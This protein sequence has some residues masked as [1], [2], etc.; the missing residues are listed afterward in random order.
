MIPENLYLV[1]RKAVLVE[2]WREAFAGCK[3][4][5]AERGDYFDFPAD[6]MVSPANSFGFMGGGLDLAIRETL[7]ADIQARVQNRILEK[8]HGE[9][10][11]GC[12]EIVETG[13]ARW[14][15]LICAPTMRVP[16][17]VSGSLNAYLA[18]RA[19]LLAVK[20][21]ND[22]TG[23]AAIQSVLA[24]GLATATGRMPPRRCALQMRVA[25]DQLN[26][27]PTIDSFAK[28]RRQHREMQQ[29]R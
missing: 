17:D 5:R 23:T 7:G 16:E 9:L 20:R 4:V 24:P 28:I 27:P 2:A 18:F 26:A 14:P 8:H 6:A 22:A 29:T 11:V 10:P 21:F 1:D 12:A 25:Y 3:Q 15:Y 13:D 19:V